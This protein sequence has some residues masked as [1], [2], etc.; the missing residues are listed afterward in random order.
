MGASGDDKYEASFA[1]IEDGVVTEAERPGRIGDQALKSGTWDATSLFDLLVFP[2]YFCS[3]M[4]QRVYTCH[5]LYHTRWTHLCRIC[6]ANKYAVL[7]VEHTLCQGEV[8]SC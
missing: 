3:R 5:C 4:D 1:E 7:S 2:T 8:C 6:L